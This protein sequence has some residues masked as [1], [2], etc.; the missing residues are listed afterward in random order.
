MAPFPCSL[1]MSKATNELLAGACNQE[2][3][4]VRF[5]LYTRDTEEDRCFG[6]IV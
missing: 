3:A 6:V 2:I 4:A 1:L 5:P